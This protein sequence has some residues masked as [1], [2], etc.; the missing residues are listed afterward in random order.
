[1]T[2]QERMKLVEKAERLM[3]K[4]SMRKTPLKREIVCALM[5][6]KGPL[7]QGELIQTLGTV[8][9]NVDRV[10]VYR[11]LNLLKA[12]G[13]V[14]EVDVNSYVCCSHECEAHP[15]L[16]F[17]CLKCHRHQEVKDHQ[18]IDTL[19][20]ALGGFRFFGDNQPLFLRGICTS[21]AV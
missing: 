3:D 14:H 20:S 15:H 12:A 1:M 10:S 19:M 9:E 8:F 4:H 13:L 18:K 7:S 6:E 16:L 2:N 17:F 11:N 21:C 5:S